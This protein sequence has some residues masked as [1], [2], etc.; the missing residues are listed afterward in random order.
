[1]PVGRQQSPTGPRK[2]SRV[3]RRYDVLDQ[4]LV[5]FLNLIASLILV[6]CK[7]LLPSIHLQLPMPIS[8]GYGI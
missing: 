3:S 6:V 8:L 7:M 5:V 2:R 4:L 1:M